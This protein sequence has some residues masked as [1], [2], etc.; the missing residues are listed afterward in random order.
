VV[1]APMA[2]H[3]AEAS[4]T[5]AHCSGVNSS[6]I[7]LL[8]MM[9]LVPSYVEFLVFFPGKTLFVRVK[10]PASKNDVPPFAERPL[11][12]IF[13]SSL[14]L[15]VELFFNGVHFPHQ[16]SRLAYESTGFLRKAT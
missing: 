16:V 8:A 3:F 10:V 1:L 9:F 15:A 5:L 4:S 7:V 6:M 11:Q 14:K 2:S 13:E 12:V